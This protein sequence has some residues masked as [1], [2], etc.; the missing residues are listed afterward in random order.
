MDNNLEKVRK[1]YDLTVYEYHKGIDPLS[2]LPEDFRES[3]QFKAFIKDT[4]PALTGSGALEYK[5]YLQ[6]RRGMRF[7]D[8]GCCANLLNYRFDLW[9]PTYYGV[10]FSPKL[11]NA[12]RKF[13]EKKNL[14][15]GGLYLTEL[16]KLPFE[17]GF[18]DIAAAVGVF[19]Y[20]TLEYSKKVISELN[21]VLKSGAK[22]IFDLPNLEHPYINVM[23]KTEEYLGRPN[24]PKTKSEFEEILTPYFNI[25][26]SDNSLVMTKYFV[27][28]KK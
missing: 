26:K 9:G 20:L 21:R 5:K 1:S 27:K 12:M 25:E 13:A 19:E 28:A 8:A 17:D 11:I 23:F 14:D 4:G 2:K 24:I 18:F 3:S 10:D 16:A 7:L 15:I 6:P 22:M